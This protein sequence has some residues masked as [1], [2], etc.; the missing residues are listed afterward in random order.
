[1]KRNLQ[2]AASYLKYQRQKKS[3]QRQRNLSLF[4]HTM[5]WPTSL[6]KKKIEAGL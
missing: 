1:M 4:A 2:R 5:H 6:F 3:G